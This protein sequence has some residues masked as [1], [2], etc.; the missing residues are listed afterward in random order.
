MYQ[1]CMTQSKHNQTYITNVMMTSM[2]MSSSSI[3]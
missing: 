3:F 2:T 1:G